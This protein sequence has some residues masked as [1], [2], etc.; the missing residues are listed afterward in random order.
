MYGKGHEDI[1]IF[2]LG[3]NL[4]QFH[5]TPALGLRDRLGISADEKLLVFSGFFHP[6]RRLENMFRAMAV[7]TRACGQQVRLLVLGDGPDFSRMVALTESLGIQNRVTFAGRVDY[8]EMPKY[9]SI[10]DIGIAFVTNS[11]EYGPMP[12]LKTAEMLACDL[13]IVASDTIGNRTFVKDGYN[14][15]IAREDPEVMGRAIV[16]LIEDHE[17]QSRLKAAA[18]ASIARYDYQ[19]IVRDVIIP[20]Y[21]KMID[22]KVRVR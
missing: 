20:F 22:Q 15:I 3:V 6:T 12:A 9:L 17:L 4:Q 10:A 21:Q 16:R 14:E 19:A 13:P 11:A 18:R 2:S 7:V 8:E 1:P 5:R